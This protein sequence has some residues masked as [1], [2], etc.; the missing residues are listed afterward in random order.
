MALWSLVD[1]GLVDSRRRVIVLG[2]GV[3]G[4]KLQLAGGREDAL[5]KASDAS[6]GPASYGR[7]MLGLSADRFVSMWSAV[8]AAVVTGEGIA[9]RSVGAQRAQRSGPAT[10]KRK[11]DQKCFQEICPFGRVRAPVVGVTGESARVLRGSTPKER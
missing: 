7:A 2:P 5:G 8:A 10:D 1:R 11:A 6:A 4:V 3:G 9:L